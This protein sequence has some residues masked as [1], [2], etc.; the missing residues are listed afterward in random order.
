[1]QQKIN[2]SLKDRDSSD[3]CRHGWGFRAGTMEILFRW[4]QY[5]D[6]GSFIWFPA[7]AFFSLNTWLNFACSLWVRASDCYQVEMLR[8]LR[9][10]CLKLRM[11]QRGVVLEI[12]FTY[13]HDF[14]QQCSKLPVDRWLYR[15]LY[16]H[17]HHHHHHPLWELA[18]HLRFWTLFSCCCCW[19]CDSMNILHT[20]CKIWEF[21]RFVLWSTALACQ[22]SHLLEAIWTKWKARPE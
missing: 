22:P 18:W 20:L 8:V 7:G 21:L 1:M 15:D 3:K 12:W 17:H 4:L 6:L 16:Y 14:M 11:L 13:L 19:W 9:C 5:L 2:T 10:L